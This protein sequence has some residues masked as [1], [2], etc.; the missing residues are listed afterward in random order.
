MQ[1]NK[2]FKKALLYLRKHQK[3]ICNALIYS[4]S[5]GKLEG[6]ND[7][8]KRIAFWFRTFRHLCLRTLV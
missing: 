5:N 1:L 7:L 6:K 8:I 4:Y 3:A 2:G